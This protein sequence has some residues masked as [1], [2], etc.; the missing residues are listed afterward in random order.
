MAMGQPYWGLER[1]PRMVDVQRLY[2]KGGITM[3]RAAN[4][5]RKISITIPDSL[6]QQLKQHLSYDQSRSAYISSAIKHKLS[7]TKS[8]TTED[9]TTRQLMAALYARE[10][11]DETLKAL[12]LHILA[13]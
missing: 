4:P 1:A 3:K 12:L 10:D 6:F 2:E 7:G 5:T 13:K 11:V 9:A 8:L